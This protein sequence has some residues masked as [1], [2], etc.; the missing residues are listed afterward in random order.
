MTALA[1]AADVELDLTCAAPREAIYF[2]ADADRIQVGGDES[3]VEC[4]QV[5]AA[6]LDGDGGD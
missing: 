1:E 2:D 3:A 5:L 6:L 4:D